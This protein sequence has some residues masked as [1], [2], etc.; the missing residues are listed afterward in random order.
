MSLS[1]NTILLPIHVILVSCMTLGALRLGKEA[2][3]AWLSFLAVALNL[4]VL[5]QISLFGL[6]VTCSDAL[7]I[8]YLLGL[9][10]VQEFFGRILARKTVWISFFISLS[11][12]ILSQ[13]HLFYQPNSYDNSHSYYRALLTPMPRLLMASLFSFLIVQLFDLS[14]FAFLRKKTEGKFLAPRTA[15]AL[16]CTQALDTLLFSFLGL[17]GLI[18]HLSHV[19]IF[20]LIVKMGVIFLS[21]P[22]IYL[23]RKVVKHA[24]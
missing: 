19:I 6:E 7:V 8:G 5:K 23:S 13:I 20:S 10:L 2:M 24:I 3:I 12:V 1:S 14:F 18:D 17:Y 11:F 4:F 9:N 21:T 16:A 22:F 15:L